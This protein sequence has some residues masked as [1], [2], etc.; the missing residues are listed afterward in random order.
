MPGVTSNWKLTLD[1]AGTPIVLV[2]IGDRLAGEIE[3][4][5]E[6]GFQLVPLVRSAAPFLR[7]GRN[8]S[9]SISFGLYKSTTTD[10]LA[11]K[12]LMQDMLTALAL[13]KKPLKIEASGITDRYWLFAEALVTSHRPQR[14]YG[15]NAARRLTTYQIIATTLTVVAV[16]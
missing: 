10:A 12:E 11:R 1:P 8:V 6:R 14:D 7:N 15:P 4:G 2:A 3:F 9:A 16:P 13:D 5:G